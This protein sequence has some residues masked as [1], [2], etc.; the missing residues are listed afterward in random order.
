MSTSLALWKGV[1][2]HNILKADSVFYKGS[3]YDI[4]AQASN[5]ILPNSTVFERCG[6]FMNTLGFVQVNKKLASE[7]AI[8]SY[9]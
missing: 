9:L 4:G 2:I 1:G 3:H 5:F 6:L 7:K 8:S